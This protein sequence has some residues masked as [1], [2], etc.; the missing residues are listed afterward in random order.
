M[1][2]NRICSLI[3]L[4]F[5]S[6]FLFAQSK[7][8]TINTEIPTKG[9]VLHPWYG[10]RIAYI[11]DS[12]TDPKNYSDKIKKYWSFLE[13]WLNITPYVYG[14]SGRQWNDVPRQT[15]LLKKEQGNDIDAI[16]VLMGTN[17]FNAGIPV[18]EWYI[19]RKAEV[20]AARGEP[21]KLVTRM[22]RDFVMSN[23]TYKGRINIGINRL[24]QLFPDKQIVLLTPLHRSFAKFSEEN[25]QPDESYQ[26]LC[27]EY[28]DAYI[29]AIKEA[30]NLWGIPVIDLNALTGI[31]PMVEEQ[32][33]YFND[34]SFDRLH[35]STIGQKRMART[36][37]YQLLTLPVNFSN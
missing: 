2:T 19:E 18:G 20:M 32:L 10:K 8:T 27:G 7:K 25:V 3:L 22:K 35:P 24:K 12:L 15:E 4:A 14:I 6:T 1:K 16:L 5:F 36:L 26:N 13:E 29:Q 17:D 34:S 33:I 9:Y 37:M 30:G 11:G 28:I 31:N 23:E 21:E